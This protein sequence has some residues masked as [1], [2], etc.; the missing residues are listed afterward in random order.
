MAHR[1]GRP[2]LYDSSSEHALIERNAQLDALAQQLV[3]DFDAMPPKKREETVAYVRLLLDEEGRDHLRQRRR[4]PS[5]LAFLAHH[6]Y[7]VWVDW[8]PAHLQVAPPPTVIETI[9][10]RWYKALAEVT[11]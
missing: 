3:S 7:G 2:Q 1:R 8:M 6:V 11:Q 10:D 9:D 4:V 5:P